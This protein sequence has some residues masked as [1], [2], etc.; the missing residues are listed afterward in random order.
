MDAKEKIHS[1]SRVSPQSED[2]DTV[3]YSMQFDRKRGVDVLLE[4]QRYW[5]NMYRWA[6]R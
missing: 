4:A 1:L 5:D 2:M 3:K 6:Q